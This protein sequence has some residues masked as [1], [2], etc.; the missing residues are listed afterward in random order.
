MELIR[1]AL[2]AYEIRQALRL[3]SVLQVIW[4]SRADCDRP[5]S[6]FSTLHLSHALGLLD[7]LIAARAVRRAATLYTFEV[8]HF[9]VVPGSVVGQPYV[10]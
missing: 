6:D 4:P 3:V 2:D 10:R 1:D 9:G 5:L 7:T 8:K